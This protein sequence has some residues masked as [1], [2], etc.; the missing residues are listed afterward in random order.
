MVDRAE[1][2]WPF[3]LVGEEGVEA[4]LAIGAVVVNGAALVTVLGQTP[5]R[6]QATFGVVVM[7]S[8]SATNAGKLTHGSRCRNRG[9]DF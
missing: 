5:V 9:V 8:R 2:R 7:S 3:V 1:R 4:A 6:R